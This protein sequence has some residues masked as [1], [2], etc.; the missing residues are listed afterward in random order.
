M[1]I[2][3][4]TIRVETRG[5]EQIYEKFPQL[6][7]ILKEAIR[8]TNRKTMD[9]AEKEIVKQITNRYAISKVSLTD[10]SS[11]HGRWKVKKVVPTESD[12]SGK[13]QITGTRMPVMRFRVIPRA[14]PNQLGVPV[15]SRRVITVTTKK[16]SSQIGKPNVFLAKMKTG[17]IGVYK[18]KVPNPGGPRRMRPDG[19]KTQLPITEEYM[20]SVPEM[21]RGKQ[22]RQ[23]FD[24]SLDKFAQKTIRATL[25]KEL[26]RGAFKQVKAE[27]DKI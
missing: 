3:K 20:L 11:R 7:L 16:G 14:V 25:R 21:L 24:E 18:R 8:E 19:Q 17:H 22:L 15:A 1:P 6:E 9:F 27:L 5:F 23:K 10:Q 26:S 12:L 4:D 2:F 13:L